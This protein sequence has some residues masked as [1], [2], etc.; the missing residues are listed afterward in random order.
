M[1]NDLVEAIIALPDQ[2]FYN[3]GIG[4]Y[5]WIISNRKPADRKGKVQ[6][7][8]ARDLYQKTRKSLG[9]KRK[10]VKETKDEISKLYLDFKP[11][12]KVKI[13]DT[14]NFAFRQI[15][16]ERPLRLRFEI[17][18]ESMGRLKSNRTFSED[19][20]SRK[21]GEAGKKENLEW[22]ELR[23][24]IY[25]VLESMRGQVWQD[26]Q[27]FLADLNKKFNASDLSPSKKIIKIIWQE[28]SDRDEQAEICTD[29]KGNPEPDTDLRD[30]ENVPWGKDVYEYFEEEVKPYVSDAWIDELKVDVQD[31][32]VGRVGYE[33]PFT[34]YF[35]TYIP[36]RSVT[37]IES[38]I[39]TI[40]T[41]L[42]DL[43]K[44]L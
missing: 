11:S 12:D 42:L 28:I 24:N 34:R 43:L 10:S 8:D 22:R 44:K 19:S 1:E 36:P 21:K 17:S 13:Y 4:T 40:E 6:L 18:D 9:Q 25:K 38:D 27:E 7:I 20:P 14:T 26:R 33:I 3:T 37:E 23:K 31:G 16:I 29:A 5:I 15:T 39:E 30:N 32:K 2:M 35:Y 41:E